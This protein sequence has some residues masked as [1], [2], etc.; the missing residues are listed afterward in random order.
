MTN[1][2]AFHVADL[3]MRSFEYREDGIFLEAYVLYDGEQDPDR[4]FY[5]DQVEATI[6]FTIILAGG[7]WTV[8]DYEMIWAN[9]AHP[10]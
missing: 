4:M 3:S 9:I 8:E 1:A 5:G 2:S 7:N 6:K 10:E